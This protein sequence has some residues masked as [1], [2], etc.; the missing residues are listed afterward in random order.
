M[1]GDVI[2]DVS[3]EYFGDIGRDRLDQACPAM[4]TDMIESPAE[5]SSKLKMEQIN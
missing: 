3:G 1:S 4:S 5:F 2:G